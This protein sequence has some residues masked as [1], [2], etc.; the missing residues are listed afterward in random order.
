ML[1]KVF[2]GTGAGQ[3]TAVMDRHEE[4]ALKEVDRISGAV[5]HLRGLLLA[6]TRA[7]L[8]AISKQ[9]ATEAHRSS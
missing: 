6:A 7:E 8:R 1:P 2:K 3:E 4:H 5:D 9:R